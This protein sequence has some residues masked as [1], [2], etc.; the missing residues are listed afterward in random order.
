MT[1]EIASYFGT[2]TGLSP[3]DESKIAM[4]E[5]E[6]TIN[7]Q[8]LKIRHATGL[9]IND[10]T[11]PLEQVRKL[12]EDEL[13]SQFNA[14]SDAHTRVDGFQI[15]E[16]TTLL[17]Y[18]EPSEDDARLIVRLDEFVEMLG[19]TML[20]DEEQVANG[21]FDRLIEGATEQV[22]PYPFPR[23]EYGGLHESQA[24]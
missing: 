19:I 1:S 13:R 20:Y 9:T 11:V 4:G 6:V 12:T 23:L 17:F 10:E 5:I 22:G 7:E 21:A 8:G 16:G 24:G 14:N 18:R 3:T 2:Y 15:G